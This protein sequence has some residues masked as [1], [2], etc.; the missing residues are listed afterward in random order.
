[1]THFF[2]TL[3]RQVLEDLQ[4]TLYVSQATIH[5]TNLNGQSKPYA[6]SCKHHLT[7]RASK[8]ACELDT[9]D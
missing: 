9:S 7:S 4:V 8:R 3:C 6:L 1:M 5:A 2:T